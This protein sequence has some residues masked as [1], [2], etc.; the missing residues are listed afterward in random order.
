MADTVRV[1]LDGFVFDALAGEALQELVESGDRKGDAARARLR[2]V[3]LDE[4]PGVVVDLPE[5]FFPDATVWGPAEEPR[6]PIDARVETGTPAKRW[7]IALN[8]CAQ[9]RTR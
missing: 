8:R 4:D 7:V 2:C 6:I 3:W 1:G 5:H 9:R